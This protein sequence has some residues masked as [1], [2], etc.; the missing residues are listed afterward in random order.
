MK[1]IIL[2]GNLY[3]I[4]IIIYIEFPTTSQMRGAYANYKYINN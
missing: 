2:I 1:Y 4:K 3:L